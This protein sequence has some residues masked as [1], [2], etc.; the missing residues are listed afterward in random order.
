[1]PAGM[2]FIAQG[3]GGFF[4][5]RREVTTGDYRQCV[6]AGRCLPATRIAL[7]PAAARALSVIPDDD[8]NTTPEQLAEAWGP[9][10]NELRDEAD[11][12]V[13]CVSH[14]G[15]SD[16]CRFVGKRLPTADEW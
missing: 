4:F 12:P 6:M 11:H 9:R 10:C 5:D 15:A 16:Y 7:T 14:A 1:P 2:V 3:K 8:T 13:N